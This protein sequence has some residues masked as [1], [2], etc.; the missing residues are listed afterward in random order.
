MTTLPARPLGTTGLH[1][2]EVGFGASVIGNLHRAVS[3]E[4]AARAVEHAWERGVRYFD[5]AP[6]YGLGLSERRLG[7]ALAGVPRDE[8]VLSTKVGRLIE[9]NPHPTELDDDGFVVP[10]D[11]RRVW[12]FSPDGVRRS[13][14][15]S[16]DRLGLDHVDIAYA[17]DPDQLG[18][19]AGLDALEALAGLRDQ[20][21]VGAI[22]VGTNAPDRVPGLF[23]AGLADVVMVAGRYTLLEQGGLASALEPARAA[24]VAVVVVGVFNSG[25]LASPWPAADARYDYTRAPASTIARARRLAEVCERH[26]TT[27]PAAA[28][29][30]PL[31]HP[32]VVAIALGMRTVEQIDTNVDRYER[33]VPAELWPDLVREGLV[34]AAALR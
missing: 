9:P 21:V 33:G 2:S 1:L 30:F 5:T 3:D 4:D 8:F 20:G 13:L 17:H 23:T 7:R 24:G 19:G 12:D 16:L 34:D 26:G 11:L 27:L 15:D 10:G 25:L 29:A 32:A 18:P 31:L 28:I 14:D 6:H 22:G